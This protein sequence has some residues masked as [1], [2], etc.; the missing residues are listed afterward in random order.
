MARQPGRG[1][2]RGPMINTLLAYA[3]APL[4]P[5]LEGLH[6]VRKGRR[7]AAT[8]D[9]LLPDGFEIEVVATELNEPVQCTFGPR[10]PGAGAPGATGPE[11]PTP[12]GGGGRGCP[13]GLRAGA[14][15]APRPGLSEPRPFGVAQGQGGLDQGGV[16]Q[17]LGVVAQ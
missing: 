17:G 12:D 3:Y 13:P 16:G 4:R 7:A 14:G 11:L 10:R 8:R 15:A 2:I 6:V 1:G 5:L 9:V